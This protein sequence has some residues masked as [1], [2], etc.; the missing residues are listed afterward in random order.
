M[1]PLKRKLRTKPIHFRVDCPSPSVE[2]WGIF[3]RAKA[4][5]EQ[6]K[7]SGRYPYICLVMSL[8]PYSEGYWIEFTK[9][10]FDHSLDILI[11]EHPKDTSKSHQLA[12]SLPDHG[13]MH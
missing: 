1:W 9:P 7:A 13:E 4:K 11:D 5:F 3:N 8:H 6:L 2:S 10:N 12:E